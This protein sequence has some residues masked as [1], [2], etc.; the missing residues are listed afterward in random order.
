[1]FVLVFFFFIEGTTNVSMGQ[2]GHADFFLGPGEEEKGSSYK[3][4]V[5]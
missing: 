5:R 2:R 1:M 4:V 3:F